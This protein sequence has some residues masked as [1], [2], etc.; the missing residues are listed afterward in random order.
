MNYEH[1]KITETIKKLVDNQSLSEKESY[2]ICTMIMDGKVS[3]A[4]IGSLLTALR[5]KG[6][7]VDEITGFCRAMR[8]KMVSIK[9]SA[10]TIIDTCGTGGDGMR[11]FNISTTSAFIAAGAG[12]FVA[13]HGNRSVSSLCGSADLISGL[14]I[15]IELEPELVKECIDNIGVGFLFAP[16]FHP[17]MK[18]AVVPRK[19]IG[20]RT[21]FN[22]LGP[23]CNPAGV[24]NQIIGVCRKEFMEKIAKA[25][26]NLNIERALIVYGGDGLDEITTTTK[27]YVLEIKHGN[28]TD[29]EISPE[30]F[31]M[32]RC[33]MEDL[34]VNDNKENLEVF[35]SILEGKPGAKTDTAVLNAGAAIY[36][37]GKAESIKDGIEIARQSILSGSALNKLKE[38]RRFVNEHAKRDN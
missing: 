25:L 21:I 32:K 35:M 29:Y 3:P 33:R 28:M 5:I 30:E 13:K 14:G 9:P 31:G 36:I 6:E 10:T 20:I 19:D 16:L 26:I 15:K 4:Q 27:T 12:C 7:T 37:A 1:K 17:A 11:T 24:K 2:D 18:Y 22:L 8:E 34:V 23:L 38:L